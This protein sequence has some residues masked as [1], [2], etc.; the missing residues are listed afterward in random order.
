MS[1][2]ALLIAIGCGSLAGGLLVG[3]LY[4]LRDWRRERS[5]S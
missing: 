1:G 2:A 5:R 4:E 3:A